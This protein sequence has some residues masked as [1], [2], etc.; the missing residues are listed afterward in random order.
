MQQIANWLEKLGLGQCAQ[1]F[2]ENEI[3]VSVSPGEIIV[4]EPSRVGL[5]ASE[6]Q[7]LA[8]THSITYFWP[9][10]TASHGWCLT[11]LGQDTKGMTELTR[12]LAAYVP[13]SLATCTFLCC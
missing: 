5:C 10:A 4:G 1:I 13:L 8:E 6:M 11:M 7:S 3:D 9:F 2:A 12:G